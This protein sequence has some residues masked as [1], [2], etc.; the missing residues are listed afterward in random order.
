MTRD[1]VE[2]VNKARDFFKIEDFPGNF[3]TLLDERSGI[4]AKADTG[5]EA[6]QR[7]YK[8]TRF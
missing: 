8:E 7:R 1:V 6:Y 3:F 5:W 2:A 4:F